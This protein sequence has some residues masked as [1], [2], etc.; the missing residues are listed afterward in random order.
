MTILV[1]GA[2]GTIGGA[3]V[4]QL[5]AAGVPVKAL[6]RNPARAVLPAGV[7]VVGGDLT[8][9]GELP[10]AGVTAVFLLA[11]IE[12]EDAVAHAEAF[13]A[14]APDLRR[15][16][17]LSS[18]AV[19]VKRPGSY[20][21]HYD[22]ERVIEASGVEWTHVRPGEFMANK[23]IWARTIKAENVVRAPFPESVG[24]PV[25]EEDVAEVAVHALL[26]DG[27]AGKAYTLS[28]PEALTHVE[29]VAAIGRGLGRPITFER[30]TYGQA[31]ASLIRDEG[32]PY[33]VAEYLLGYMAQHNEEPASVTPDFT[34][35]TGHPGRTLATWA[36]DH[37]ADLT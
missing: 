12:S 8:R 9:P 18:N 34:T 16:V 37:T 1:T 6:T 32:L 14:S 24:A 29:Q 10:L 26:R 3:V 7:E 25:H 19:T 13:L 30:L 15:V 23:L 2:T 28:G 22:V 33:D 11:A 4:R 35:V 21:L 20:E 17:F 31:R 5:A 36:T 27:H